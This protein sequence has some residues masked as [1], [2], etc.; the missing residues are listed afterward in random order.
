MSDAPP[1]LSR[2][3]DGSL[4]EIVE[5]RAGTVT[6]RSGEIVACDPLVFIQGSDPFA[7]HVPEGDHEVY[8][9]RLGGEIAYARLEVDDGPVDSWE[10]ARCP[11]EEDVEGWPGY[12]VEAGVGSFADRASVERFLEAEDALAREIHAKLA[13]EGLEDPDDPAYDER[14]E[15]LRAEMG[16]DPIAELDQKLRKKDHGQVA[17]DPD[18]GILVAFKSGTGNGVFASFWGRGE[19]GALRCLVTDF[20]LLLDDE[21]DLDPLA[22]LAG[23]AG[24]DELGGDLKGLEALAKALGM[25]AEPEPE[26]EERQGPS[27]LFLQAKEL[28]QRWVKEEKLELEEGVDL[29][30]FAEAFLYKLSSLQG[31]R[32]PGAHI[33]EW[34]VERKEV[35]DVFATDDE[36]EADL[37]G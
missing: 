32:N 34:L 30:D 10:V 18:G 12:S 24:A 35:A 37:V 2:L 36:L 25:G 14:F 20:G 6:V 4:D 7:T 23:E 11:G 33:G 8:V 15:V 29:D 1:W 28:L 17:L 3:A 26:P 27:P 16:R 19:D 9:G 21:E 31:N 13:E 5:A 22:A